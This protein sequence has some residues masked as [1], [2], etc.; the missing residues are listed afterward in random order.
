MTQT[1]VTKKEIFETIS[2]I[3]TDI[4]KYDNREYRYD[5]AIYKD[6]KI[7]CSELHKDS[8]SWTKW[9]NEDQIQH[10]LHIHPVFTTQDIIDSG[11]DAYNPIELREW[12]NA[13]E[14][15]IYWYATEVSDAIY[16]GEPLDE[17]CL[18]I[19]F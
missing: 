19:V 9:Q 4:N 17:I 1:K 13:A 6:M 2:N 10:V 5:V 11:Y 12:E 18:Q 7:V 16:Y 3:A 15:G 8:S 14:S